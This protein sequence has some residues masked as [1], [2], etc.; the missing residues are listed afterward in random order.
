MSMSTDAIERAT[1]IRW[2][3]WGTWLS[4]QGATSLTHA[5]LARLVLG[6]IHELGIGAHA[7]TGDTLNDGWWAQSIAIAFEH[8]HG[9]RAIGQDN[10]GNFSAAASKTVAGTLDDALAAWVRVVEHTPEIGGVT[11]DGASSTSATEKWRYWRATLSDG[12]RVQVDISERKS[13]GA[14]APKAVVSVQHTRLSSAD[15]IPSRKAEWKELLARL[16]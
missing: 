9:M 2:P 8:E 5:A 16:A 7:A 12:S 10:Q 4:A 14:D 6:R 13:A 11:W 1:G 15:E 3:E